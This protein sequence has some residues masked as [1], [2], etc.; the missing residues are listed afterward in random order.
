MGIPRETLQGV[1]PAVLEAFESV[2][3]TLQTLGTKMIDIA[4]PNMRYALST[5]YLIAPS[6]ASSNLARFDGVHYGYRTKK[7]DSAEWLYS[8]SRGEGFGKEVKLRIMLGTY[9]LSSGYYDAYYLKANQVRQLILSDFEAAFKK[10]QAI[11]I[12]T[13]PTTAFKL[14]DKSEDPITM[15][16]SDVFTLP[17]NLAGIAGISVP[18]GMDAKSLPIGVQ[19]IGKA[20]AEETILQMAHVYEKSRGAFAR[21]LS[22]DEKG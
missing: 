17:I 15:Y 21:P 8:K 7:A 5:Y 11:L 22:F 10:C 1:E 13:S 20:F 12:P 6:E 16:L 4:L 2:V 18:C 19:F 9:A 3:T 14:G